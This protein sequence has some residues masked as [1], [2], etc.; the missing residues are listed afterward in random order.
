LQ[1]PAFD[2]DARRAQGPVL[3]W[4]DRLLR[5]PP[6][7]AAPPAAGRLA[8]LRTDGG[9]GKHGGQHGG[10]PR[11]HVARVALGHLLRYNLDMFSVCVD[12]CYH[13]DSSIATGYFQV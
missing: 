10:P 5:A 1:G 3:Q 9:D 8:L 6:G 2:T 4:I 12:R 7:Q 13:P 11:A